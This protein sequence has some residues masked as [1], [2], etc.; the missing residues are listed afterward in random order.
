V[1]LPPQG[2]AHLEGPHDKRQLLAANLRPK[3]RNIAEVTTAVAAA[4]FNA[5][6]SRREGESSSSTNTINNR[7]TSSTPALPPEVTRVAARQVRA[8]RQLG[9]RPRYGRSPDLE[10]LDRYVNV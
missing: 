3:V 6:S 7:V 1:P 2:V 5:K 8:R 4:P 9:V 10:G